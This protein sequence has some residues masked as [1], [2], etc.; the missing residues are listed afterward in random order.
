ML[1]ESGGSRD[2]PESARV[3]RFGRIRAA[4]GAIRLFPSLLPPPLV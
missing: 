2:V 4:V 1:Q 3:I